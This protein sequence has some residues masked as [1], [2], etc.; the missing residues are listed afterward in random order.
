MFI[1]TAA[2]LQKEQDFLFLAPARTKKP[3]CMLSPASGIRK[4]RRA[5]LIRIIRIHAFYP[6]PPNLPVLT[7]KNS[8]NLLVKV[9]LGSASGVGFKISE[10]LAYLKEQLFE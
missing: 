6:S 9:L 7:Q 10:A 4:L 1:P 5:F 3:L 8:V 2:M